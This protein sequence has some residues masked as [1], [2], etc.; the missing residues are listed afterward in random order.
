MDVRRAPLLRNVDPDEIK[1]LEGAPGNLLFAHRSNAQIRLRM[2]RE[3]LS[4]GGR[5]RVPA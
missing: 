1:L 2:R 4:A 5:I 3:T